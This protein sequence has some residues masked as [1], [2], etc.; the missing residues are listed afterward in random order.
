LIEITFNIIIAIIA[1]LLV[2]FVLN[3]KNNKRKLDT[4]ILIAGATIMLIINKPI[5]WIS[6]FVLIFVYFFIRKSIK[7]HN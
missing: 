2:I 3:Q 6:I 7:H 1:V 4:I 5:I